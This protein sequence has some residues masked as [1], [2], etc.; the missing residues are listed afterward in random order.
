MRILLTG[1]ARP[2]HRSQDTLHFRILCALQG[3]MRRKKCRFVLLMGRIRTYV[4]IIL[5]AR[6]FRFSGCPLYSRRA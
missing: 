5:R 2:V 6:F 4:R 1:R 3:S